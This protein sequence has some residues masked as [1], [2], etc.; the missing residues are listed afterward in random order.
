MRGGMD[1]SDPRTYHSTAAVECLLTRG[2]GAGGSR[3]P[4]A[5]AVGFQLG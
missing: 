5:L 4:E 2:S 3:L 1:L